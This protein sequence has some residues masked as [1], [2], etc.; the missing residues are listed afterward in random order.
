MFPEVVTGASCASAALINAAPSKTVWRLAAFSYRAGA[1]RKIGTAVLSY[2][3]VP[4][5]TREYKRSPMPKSI[6]A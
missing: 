6:S 1:N 2:F 3:N 5:S 4:N